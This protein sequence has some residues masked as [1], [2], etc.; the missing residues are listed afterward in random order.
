MSVEEQARGRVLPRELQ[1]EPSLV[2]VMRLG[3]PPVWKSPMPVQGIPWVSAR[4]IPTGSQKQYLTVKRGG[5][6]AFQPG[7]E[8]K[9]NTRARKVSIQFMWNKFTW[10]AWS[11]AA[12][13][14]FCLALGSG[15]K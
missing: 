15:N 12:Y 2:Q 11:H 3:N 9:R 13:L 8:P 14:L 4:V 6:F 5:G 1:Q 10:H 7:H